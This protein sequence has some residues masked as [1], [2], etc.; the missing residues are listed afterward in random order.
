MEEKV[1]ENNEII[2]SVCV[3]TYNHQKYLTECLDSILG[4]IT[5]F[6]YE[7]I[8]YD[9]ASTDGTTDIVKNYADKYPDIII[10]VLQKENQYSKHGKIPLLY[11]EFIYPKVR[12]RYVAYCEGDDYWSDRYKLS[13]QLETLNKNPDCLM[14]LHYTD[15]V[16]EK[17]EH[18]EGSYPQNTIKEGVISQNDFLSGLTD[19]YFFHTTSFFCRIEVIEKLLKNVPDYYRESD[20]DDVPFLLFIGNLGVVYFIDMHMSCYRRNSLGS[21]TEQQ[22]DN[23]ERII[24]HKKRMI[25]MYEMYDDFSD[26]KY[27]S[28]VQH[29]IHNEEFMIL[30]ISHDFKKM[31]KPE[32]KEFLV[33]RSL[34]FKIKV[35]LA[36]LLGII[37]R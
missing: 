37:K 24:Q 4:Q 10:P 5:D 17:G 33:N 15:L 7:M 3:L 1:S 18:I 20:V 28:I 13:R 12:G 14:C 29:W 6:K 2:V 23:K 11:Q 34:R 25:H 21:W 9:D 19:G 27:A 32:Y 22:K 16:N 31:I 30:E 8:I 36:A 35:Y 26:H